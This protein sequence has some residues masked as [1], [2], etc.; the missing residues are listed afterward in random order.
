MGTS[1]ATGPTPNRGMEAAAMQRL[2]VSVKNLQG[3]VPMLDASTPLAKD[4]L[5]CIS[6]LAKHV[7]PGALSPAG[8]KNQIEQM[9]IRAAQQAHTMQQLR[10][11]GGAPGAPPGAGG[12]PGGAPPGPPIPR[13]A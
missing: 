3:V 2:A 11:P 4:V 6:K 13:A 1:S 5:D 8:E 10:Q 9:A 7:P 12:P